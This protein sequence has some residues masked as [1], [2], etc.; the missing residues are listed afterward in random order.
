MFYSSGE[1]TE[2]C[3]F[4]SSL[5]TFPCCLVDA[6]TRLAASCLLIALQGGVE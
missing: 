2:V 4:L 5:F 1:W 3:T 6:L